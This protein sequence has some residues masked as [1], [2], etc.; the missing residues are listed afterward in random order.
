MVTAARDAGGLD[1]ALFSEMPE[2]AVA[3]I[4]RPVVSVPEVTRGHDPEGADCGQRPAFG[5]TQR[6]FAV[7]GVTVVAWIEIHNSPRPGVGRCRNQADVRV[8]ALRRRVRGSTSKTF[9]CMANKEQTFVFDANP[10]VPYT[11]SLIAL[12]PNDNVPG[13]L[14]SRV[15]AGVQVPMRYETTGADKQPVPGNVVYRDVGDAIECRA[16]SR[17]DGRFTVH[18]VF[19]QSSVGSP[20]DPPASPASNLL[21]PVIRTFRSE[22]SLVLADGQ[23]VRHSAG[24][25]RVTGETVNIDVTLTAMK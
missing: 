19:E 25:D 12:A 23:T 5:P 7:A 22:A 2:V 17:E 18:C 11:V 1:E 13:G 4:S 9:A 3:K 15:R 8:S 21:P 14:P 16:S 20:G 10:S 6:V 24:I